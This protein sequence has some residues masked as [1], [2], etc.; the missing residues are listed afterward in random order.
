MYIVLN[1]RTLALSLRSP[2]F[3]GDICKFQLLGFAAQLALAQAA[4]IKAFFD[5]VL[6]ASI[7]KGGNRPGADRHDGQLSRPSSLVVLTFDR[8]TRK[9]RHASY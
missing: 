1:Y 9:R 3:V 2:T 5:A 7:L 8:T 4:R 6:I